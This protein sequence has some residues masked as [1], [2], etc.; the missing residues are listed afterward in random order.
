MEQALKRWF[1]TRRAAKHIDKSEA[2]LKTWRSRGIGPPFYK[3]MGGLVYYRVEDLDAWI[4][5]NGP[6][7][8]S[9]KR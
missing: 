3:P 5:Q 4:E 9:A 7:F 1:T 6:Q 2:T 8:T